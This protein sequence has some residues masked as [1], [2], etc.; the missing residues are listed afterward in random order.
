MARMVS[1][2]C[3]EAREKLADWFEDAR[4]RPDLL[5]KEKTGIRGV[6]CQNNQRRRRGIFVARAARSNQNSVQERHIPD[7]APTE[8]VIFCRRMFY[9]DAAPLA[10]RNGTAGRPQ[11]K[12]GAHPA[13]A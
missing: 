9:K 2:R 11:T 12:R 1:E 5:T 8:L 13:S 4:P 6:V 7:V 10:L 3:G